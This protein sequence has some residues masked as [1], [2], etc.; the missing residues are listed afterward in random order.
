VDGVRFLYRRTRGRE[1]TSATFF[2]AEWGS[3]TPPEDRRARSSGEG[4][5]YLR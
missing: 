3:H 4:G 2:V 1:P 5:G